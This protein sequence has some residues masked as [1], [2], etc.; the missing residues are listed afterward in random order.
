MFCT[1]PFATFILA[2]FFIELPHLFWGNDFT[3]T[4]LVFKTQVDDLF[5]IVASNLI[6]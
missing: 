5:I 4:I 1:H 2:F 3:F 6:F